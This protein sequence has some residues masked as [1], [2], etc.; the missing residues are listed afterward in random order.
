MLIR[1]GKADGKMSKEAKNTYEDIINMAH[2]T[3]KRHPRMT[4][5]NRAAQFSPFAALTGHE[6]ALKETARITDNKIELDEN[7]K[8]ELD[9]KLQQ[10]LNKNDSIQ[11]VQITYFKKDARKAGGNY[12]TMI[13]SIKKLDMN[14]KIITLQNKQIINLSD[15]YEI[16]AIDH[17]D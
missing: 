10:I 13:Q 3:S 7:V 11:N 4:V 8:R 1:Y 6:E 17:N 5:Y 12:Q 14:N 2:P 16:E 15:I 9:Y